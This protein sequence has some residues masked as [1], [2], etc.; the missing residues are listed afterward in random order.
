MHS[1]TKAVE[2][3]G[4]REEKRVQRG[5]FCFGAW[6]VVQALARC[7]LVR[8]GACSREHA[9]TVACSERLAAV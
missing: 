5:G 7:V 4:G 1:E 6:G 3:G 9:C 2:G 8:D